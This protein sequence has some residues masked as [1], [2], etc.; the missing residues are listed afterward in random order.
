MIGRS[1]FL[2]QGLNKS[3]NSTIVICRTC[4]LEADIDEGQYQGNFFGV[5][6]TS[7]NIPREVNAISGLVRKRY[8]IPYILKCKTGMDR[9]LLK[10]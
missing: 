5:I 9:G 6:L 2:A 7:K 8:T 10:T 4:D 3:R 1:W